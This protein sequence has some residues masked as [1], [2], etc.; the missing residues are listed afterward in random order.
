[1]Y[2]ENVFLHGGLAPVLPDILPVSALESES[3]VDDRSMFSTTYL[4]IIAFSSV[5]VKFLWSWSRNIQL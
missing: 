3:A 5:S 2:L 4:S 1:M